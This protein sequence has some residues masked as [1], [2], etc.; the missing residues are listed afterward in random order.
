MGIA[1]VGL[2][3]YV[4]GFPLYVIC[5]LVRIDQKQLH[6]DP[7]T[8]AKYG[9]FYE[10]Y[11]PHAF[12]YGLMPIAR[13][14]VFGVLGPFG[15][16]P[17]MQ[18]LFGLIILAAQFVSQVKMNPYINPHVDIS[19][20]VLTLVLLLLSSCGLIFAVS[21]ASDHKSTS[22]RDWHFE[23][24]TWTTY[25]SMVFGS[26]LTAVLTA[27]SV[28]ENV[29]FSFLNRTRFLGDWRCD[30]LEKVELLYSGV[31]RA[32]VATI[33]QPQPESPGGL[34]RQ[35]KVASRPSALGKVFLP[36]F[37]SER[38]LGDRRRDVIDTD[39]IRTSR[40]FH[41]VSLLH[42][43]ALMKR[44]PLEDKHSYPLPPRAP[45]LHSAAAD[46]RPPAQLPGR[47]AHWVLAFSLAR[48]VVHR[49]SGHLG[50]Q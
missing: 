50:E 17:E 38:I 7:R 5:T 25:L 34:A 12:K 32:H 42:V 40:L 11:E 49:E 6:S 29:Y 37:A 23:M 47:N 46:F 33:C 27:N 19:E 26:L 14:G 13:R 8:L 1:T 36:I 30:P 24:L 9:A 18:C 16:F 44:L 21:P 31:A 2:V 10:K 22:I 41:D 43:A 28:F 45:L 15:R 48:P 4:A 3:V 20:T 39:S 35:A